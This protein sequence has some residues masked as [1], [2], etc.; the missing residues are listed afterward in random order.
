M[1]VAAAVGAA[2]VSAATAAAA[3]PH[4]IALRVT[5]LVLSQ[6]RGTNFLIVDFAPHEVHVGGT[7]GTKEQKTKK[8]NK[9]M[10]TRYDDKEKYSPKWSKWS[11]QG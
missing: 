5:E 7:S 8:M 3:S 4:G 2:A 11:R 1:A 6:E 10:H 9:I